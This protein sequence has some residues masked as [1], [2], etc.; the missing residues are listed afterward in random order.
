MSALTDEANAGTTSVRDEYRLDEAALSRWMQRHVPDFLGPIEVEQFKGGQ[1][2]PTYKLNTPKA[3]YVLRRKPPGTLLPGAHDVEREARVLTALGGVGFPVAHVYGVCAQPSILGSPFFVMQMVE[4]RIFWDASFPNVAREERPAY[5]NAMNSTLARLHQI[6][7]A[8][9]GLSDFGKPGNYFARQISRW[10]KQ[11]LQDSDAGR[12][13]NMD[14]LLEWLPANI[15][16]DDQT[17]IAH[18]DFRCDNMIFH[19]L[20]PRILAVLD[21]ELSTLG[22]PLA[23][24]AYHAIMYRMPP[25]IVAGLQGVDL[26][27][28]N[29]PTE[30]QYL[31]GYCAR[32]G[33]DSILAYDFYIAF[34]FFRL[35]AIFHGIKGRVIRGTAASSHAKERAESFPTLARLASESMAACG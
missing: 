9:V 14:R 15:P 13:A 28:L 34:N 2:N 19:P 6:D 18:G 27:A 10:S 20:E 22:H 24:F 16:D 23:D 31:A 30:A 21:W 8:A 1:S 7:Y 35:A 29:I 17:C 26:Q 5:F 33:R 12:D 32:T 25:N 11:Y 3:S 4:G